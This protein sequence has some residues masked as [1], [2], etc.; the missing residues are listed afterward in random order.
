MP[1]VFFM[2]LFC[3][4]ELFEAALERMDLRGRVGPGRMTNPIAAAVALLSELH[5]A[6]E[7]ENV[8]IQG[9]T[10]DDGAGEDLHNPVLWGIPFFSRSP[11]HRKLSW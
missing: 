9:Q 2:C 10:D 7:E 5:H 3:S 4:G 1:L 6:R 11:H 8:V